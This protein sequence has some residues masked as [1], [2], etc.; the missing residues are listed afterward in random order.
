MTSCPFVSVIIPCYNA[1]RYV[2]FAGR[3]I[4]GGRCVQF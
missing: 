4:M 2:E 3:S 1:E